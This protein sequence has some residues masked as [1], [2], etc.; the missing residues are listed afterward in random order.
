MQPMPNLV[1]IG[2]ATGL[3]CVAAETV[4]CFKLL[5]GGWRTH[6]WRLL[7]PQLFTSLNMHALQY[8]EVYKLRIDLVT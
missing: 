1:D 2:H 3:A 7:R 6:W 4:T 8:Q 5:T